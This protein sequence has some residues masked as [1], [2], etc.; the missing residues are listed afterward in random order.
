MNVGAKTG[1]E[2]IKASASHWKADKAQRLG[3]ALAYYAVVALPP[4]LVIFLFIISLFY[5]PRSASSQFSQQL[6]SLL[7]ESGGR[8]M[9][10][11]MSNP[12]IHGK[13][14]T[15][16][17]IAI[18]TLIL[19]AS[20]FFLELQSA[21]NSVWGV[22]QRPEIG[23]R[24][25]ILNRLLSF[26]SLIVIGVLI[27]VSLLVSTVLAAVQRS[28]GN[29]IPGGQT[30]W[31]AVEFIASF[32]IGTL[33]FAL[34]Y[35][36]LP[37]VRVRWRDVLVGGAMTALLFTVGKILLGLYL[38]RSS[39]GSAYGVAGSLVLILV[40][41]YYSAQIF[42][43][44]AEFTQAYA[45]R[46]GKRIT[47]SRHARW[48]AE[49]ESAAEDRAE[50]EE[51]SG[52]EPQPVRTRSGQVPELGKPAQRQIPSAQS[53]AQAGGQTLREIAGR[54]HSWHSIRT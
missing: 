5:D 41:I 39:V 12:Q 21:L 45:N 46:L 1:W 25:L 50:V 27:V 23:W 44:G 49:G 16:T 7:G 31:R 38:G 54:I 30:P 32:G 24:G 48:E 3:A 28:L 29:A 11:L 43:F 40:W 22:E 8:F 18:I 20:G 19:T 4:I 15:A 34:I 53:P 51:G 10:T 9:Q 6:N 13:G 33:L 17:S 42:L 35:K 26:L 14:L 52:R 37:D 36:I 47:P 2:L